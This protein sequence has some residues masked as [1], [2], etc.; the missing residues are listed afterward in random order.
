MEELH[1]LEKLQALLVS[2]NTQGTGGMMG[3]D[4]LISYNI[5]LWDSFPAVNVPSFE[6]Y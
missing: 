5:C 4:C 6:N 1:S 3:G 2:S